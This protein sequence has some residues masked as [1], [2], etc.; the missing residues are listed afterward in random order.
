MFSFIK[1][2]FIGLLTSVVNASNY[3][4]CSCLTNQKST[5][6]PALINLHS[7]EVPQ[8]LHYYPFAINLDR[9]V[10]SCNNLIPLAPRT[11][12]GS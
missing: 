4:K 1:K 10:G 8:R 11:P 5:T 6:Q 2:M 12:L 7:N 9:S 3:I